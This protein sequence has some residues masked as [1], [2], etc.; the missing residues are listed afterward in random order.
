MSICSGS[1][2]MPGISCT[3]FLV[4]ERYTNL[5]L[6]KL[7]LVS[8]FLHPRNWPYKLSGT[9]DRNPD[10][11]CSWFLPLNPLNL[12]P[13]LVTVYGHQL[14]RGGVKF[15]ICLFDTFCVTPLFAIS[16]ISP[17]KVRVTDLFSYPIGQSRTRLTYFQ[18]LSVLQMYPVHFSWI[19]NASFISAPGHSSEHQIPAVSQPQ[20][21]ISCTSQTNISKT[22]STPSPKLVHL[23]SKSNTN[24]NTY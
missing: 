24:N 15:K 14:V 3:F 21:D 17:R 4:W 1:G 23:N 6:R 16:T 20:L 10:I 19:L 13:T 9:Q 2:A 18:V 7:K 5:Q 8:N 12:S 22:R 11:V